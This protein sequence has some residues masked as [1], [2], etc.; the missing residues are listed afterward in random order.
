MCRRRP[1][2][3]PTH[4]PFVATHKVGRHR[5]PPRQPRVRWTP[6]RRPQLLA[7]RS[8]QCRPEPQD[9]RPALDPGRRFNDDGK[10]L[11]YERGARLEGTEQE[12]WSSM[13]SKDEREVEEDART[14]ASAGLKVTETTPLVYSKL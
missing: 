1:P 7:C 4:L 5:R 9:R 14:G 3:R 6:L 10:H 2:G 8:F 12:H 11:L 13:V